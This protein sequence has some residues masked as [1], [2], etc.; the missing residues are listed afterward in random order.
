MPNATPE[1]T[2]ASKREQMEYWL[3]DPILRPEAE[4]WAKCND[5]LLEYDEFGNAVRFTKDPEAFETPEV[6]QR[7]LA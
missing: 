4:A 3:T 7:R 5:Y 1:R 2:F 6:R